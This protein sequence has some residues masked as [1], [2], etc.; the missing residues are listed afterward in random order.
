MGNEPIHAHA[1]SRDTSITTNA[2]SVIQNE[3]SRLLPWVMLIALLAGISLG[4]SVVTIYV[5]ATAYR[6]LEREN[7]ITQMQLDNM[8][9]ALLATSIDPAPHL[10]GEAP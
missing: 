3:S 10:K 9:V 2:P 1:Q 8:K 7:R 6:T 4:V 5:Q